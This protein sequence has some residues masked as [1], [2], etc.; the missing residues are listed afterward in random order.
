[1]R[2]VTPGALIKTNLIWQNAVQSG[3]YCDESR[4][5]AW[6][7]FYTRAAVPITII[8]SY[9]F[10]GLR[11][12]SFFLLDKPSSLQSTFSP[13]KNYSKAI[14]ETWS[15]FVKFAILKFRFAN[16][17]PYKSFI[18]FST[19]PSCCALL[20]V[21]QSYSTNKWIRRNHFWNSL[22]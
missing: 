16:L 14:G 21:R 11:V 1:M 18:A 10:L 13:N 12:A 2:E 8:T 19:A 15:R 6:S 20:I 4:L 3:R 5:K 9:Q 22:S 7:S 17:F